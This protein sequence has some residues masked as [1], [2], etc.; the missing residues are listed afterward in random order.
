ME[1]AVARSR[2]PFRSGLAAVAIAALLALV[3]LLVGVGRDPETIWAFDRTWALHECVNVTQ[4]S[5]Q[6]RFMDDAPGVAPAGS[7]AAFISVNAN[8][9]N[10]ERCTWRSGLN[11]TANRMAITAAVNDGASLR[12]TA[13]GGTTC[14]STRGAAELTGVEAD[15]APRG[16]FSPSWSTVT[17]RSI[18]ITL[19]DSPASAAQ[20]ISALVDGIWLFNGATTVWQENFGAAG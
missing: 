7:E 17:I 12:I 13:N 14:G 8:D 15:N 6:Y 20:R 5:T 2:R 4:V 19:S 1:P 11:A 16:K 18:C 9:A 3:A 10:A